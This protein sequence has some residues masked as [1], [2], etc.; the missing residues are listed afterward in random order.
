MIE[1][2]RAST[3]ETLEY[4][5]GELDAQFRALHKRRRELDPPASVFALEHG[6]NED[7]SPCSRRPYGRLIGIGC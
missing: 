6:L 1:I 3:A 2:S 5:H 7:D 4:L